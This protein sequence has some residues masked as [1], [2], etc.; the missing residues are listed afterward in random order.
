MTYNAW[1]DN[2]ANIIK[3][4]NK[5]MIICRCKCTN[6]MVV[7]FKNKYRKMFDIFVLMLALY[8]SV[9]IPLKQ[10]Y[11]PEFKRTR[12]SEIMD[13]VIDGIFLIDILLMFHTTFIDNK[14]EEI[15]NVPEIAYNY[16]HTS[17]FIVDL[18]S[19]LGSA[20]FTWIHR[21]FNLF[22][23]FKVL[24]VFRISSLITKSNMDG[25]S[26]AAMKLGKL[27]FYLIFYLHVIACYWWLILEY[28]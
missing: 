9:M 15:W 19:L 10:C 3:L 20:A 21:Y 4:K 5:K 14:G 7:S 28:G 24:R 25:S 26:K 8:N 18:L 23:F 17:R 12:E 1:N 11:N 13:M 22:G 2:M 16:S 27:I 6:W